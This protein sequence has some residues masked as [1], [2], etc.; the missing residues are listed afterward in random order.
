M[1]LLISLSRSRFVRVALVCSASIMLSACESR[2]PAWSTIDAKELDRLSQEDRAL[3]PPKMDMA[4]DEVKEVSEVEAVAVDAQPD[5]LE[6]KPNGALGSF[7]LDLEVRSTDA[8]LEKRFDALEY[9]VLAMHRDLKLMVPYVQNLEAKIKAD[10][11]EAQK[12]AMEVEHK[13]PLTLVDGMGVHHDDKAAGGHAHDTS[14]QAK[15]AMDSLMAEK[16][17]PVMMDKAPLHHGAHVKAVRLGQHKDKIRIVFD[18][19]DKT[20]FSVDLDNDE[21]LLFVEIPGAGWQVPEAHLKALSKSSLIES[22]TLSNLNASHGRILAIQL[23]KATRV[24]LER[25][26]PAVSGKGQ[27]LVV[28]LK[29]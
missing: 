10:Q 1:S 22:Y 4:A 20:P 26:F 5:L 13:G 19:S 18:T 21:K 14:M 25:A 2:W 11:E 6:M 7:G 17:K 9:V 24:I 28:D 23:T 12:A 8:D 16:Q 15:A 27:R 29:L 3:A